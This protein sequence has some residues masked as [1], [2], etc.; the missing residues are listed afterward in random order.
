MNTLDEK[1]VRMV[2]RLTEKARG[3]TSPNPIVMAIL[4]LN[5]AVPNGGEI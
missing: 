3:R 4:L 1:Y 5:F 2:L